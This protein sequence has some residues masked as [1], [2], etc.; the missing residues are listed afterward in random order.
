MVGL[1]ACLWLVSKSFCGHSTCHTLPRGSR[2]L[3]LGFE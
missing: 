1:V 2:V 3:M